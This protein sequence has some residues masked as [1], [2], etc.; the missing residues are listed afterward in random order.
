MEVDKQYLLVGLEQTAA[1]VIKNQSN[2]MY[3][4]VGKEEKKG[5]ALQR[6]FGQREDLLS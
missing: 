5:N 2:N 3:R 1:P 6:D 4:L